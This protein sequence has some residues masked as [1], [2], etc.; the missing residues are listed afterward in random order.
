MLKKKGWYQD[1]Q[2]KL[3]AIG[4]LK[5][6]ILIGAQFSQILEYHLHS[7]VDIYN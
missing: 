2:E 7:Y 1:I 5:I 6:V 4:V 3:G